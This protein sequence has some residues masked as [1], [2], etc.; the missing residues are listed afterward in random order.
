VTPT[1]TPEIELRMTNGGRGQRRVLSARGRIDHDSA[2]YVAWAFARVRSEE[3][4]ALDLGAAE[5]ADG[6]GTVLLLHAMRRLHA[7]QQ[8]LIVVCAQ[9][10]LRRALDRSG[11]ARRFELVGESDAV[12]DAPM[13]PATGRAATSVTGGHGTRASTAA[14]RAALLAD[15]TLAMD[16]R[17]GEHDLRLHDIARDVAT[18]DRQLQR[19]F[20]ELAGSSFRDELAA[21]RMHHGADLLQT[22]ELPISEIASRVG[23]RH[24]P[25]FARVFR[26]HHGV[27]PSAL[28]RIGRRRPGPASTLITR[29]PVPSA[30]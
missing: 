20:A 6:P 16:R 28:R 11:L 3:P 9:P 27:N 30:W 15:A 29:P 26:H 23:Y 2:P 8:E 14:R 21:V 17:H 13:R 10:S 12:P 19:V 7:R 24:S 22:T 4:V 25:Q 18:S 1:A 5:V